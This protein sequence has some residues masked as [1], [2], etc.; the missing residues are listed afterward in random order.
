M[1]G[2]GQDA[3]LPRHMQILKIKFTEPI[4]REGVLSCVVEPEDLGRTSQ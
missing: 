2:T 3:G 4:Y 1:N